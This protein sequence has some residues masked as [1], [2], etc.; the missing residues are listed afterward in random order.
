[1]QSVIE[2]RVC[3]FL[4]WDGEGGESEKKKIQSPDLNCPI[5]AVFE[6]IYSHAFYY[7]CHFR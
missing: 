7:Y 5:E 4:G 3:I 6:E 2:L 1:M